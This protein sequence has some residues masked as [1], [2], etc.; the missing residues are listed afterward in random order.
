MNRNTRMIDIINKHKEHDVLP[1][2]WPA[3]IIETPPPWRQFIR[4]TQVGKSKILPSEI[5]PNYAGKG[6]GSG[7]HTPSHSLT[8]YSHGSLILAIIFA[9]VKHYL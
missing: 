7:P 9:L 3:D 8:L 6:G 5:L 4:S 1:I 2:K